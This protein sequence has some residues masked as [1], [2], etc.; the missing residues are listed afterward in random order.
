MSNT[1]NKEGKKSDK[2]GRQIKVIFTPLSIL[3][4]AAVGYFI[5]KKFKDNKARKSE[6][7][8]TAL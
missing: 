6:V 5:Y 7:V 3:F 8:T 2:K 4:Y 1:K